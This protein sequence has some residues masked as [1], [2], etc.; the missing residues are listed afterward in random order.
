MHEEAEHH[1]SHRVYYTVFGALLALLAVT[2]VVA[3][4][5]LGLVAF[6]VAV[7]VATVKAILILLY[8]MHVRYSQPLTW[9]VAGAAFFW[10]AILFG[11]TLSDYYTRGLRAQPR[12][13][14][15]TEPGALA[16]GT[17]DK[18]LPIAAKRRRQL[19]SLTDHVLRPFGAWSISLARGPGAHA[20]GFIPVPLRGNSFE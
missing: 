5:N 1:P 4:M 11:L 2:V 20:P 15:G 16:P 12:S 13:G 14:D 6:L 8:F 10:L 17:K 19:G 9:L 18:Q 7:I 3:E